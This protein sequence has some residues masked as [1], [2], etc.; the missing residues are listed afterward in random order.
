M[1]DDGARSGEG[2]QHDGPAPETSYELPM[3]PLGAVLLPGMALPL[4]VFEPRYRAMMDVVL[5]AEPPEFGVVLIERGSE[6]GGGETRTTVG[7][8]ATVLRA[9]PTP[10]GRWAVIAV[11]G[12][13][14]RVERWLP[15]DPFPAAVVSDWPDEPGEPPTVDA[16]E[17]LRDEVLEVARIAQRLGAGRVPPGLELDADPERRVH[18]LALLTPIGPLDRQRVLQAPNLSTR[19]AVLHELAREQ[20]LLLE[21]R[22]RL[23]DL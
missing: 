1:N 4:Q 23:G 3:F 11:G 19:V 9:E 18:Q 22:D 6:V 20:H 14:L 8:S 7:C 13:R 10:D 5:A 16:L 12:R 17:L 21:A 2:E 15:D